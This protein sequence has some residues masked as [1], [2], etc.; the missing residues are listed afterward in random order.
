MPGEGKT[1][2]PGYHANEAGHRQEL[3][4]RLQWICR[5]V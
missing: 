1:D 3:A 4:V 2:N 5:Y